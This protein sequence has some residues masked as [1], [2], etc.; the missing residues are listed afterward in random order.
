[1]ISKKELSELLHRLDIPVGEGEHFLD[2][3]GEYPK[4]A[5]W[6]Y[7]WSDDM[8]SGDHYLEI[9]RYQISFVSK[10]PRHKKLKELKKLINDA[11]MHPEIYHEYVKGSD[12]SAN[13]TPGT[14]HSYFY[15]DIAEDLAND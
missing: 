14:F 9:V 15:I 6:E 13:N 3:S 4:V 8:A 5:Y 11:G 2:S 7:L 10:T 12:N 1:M